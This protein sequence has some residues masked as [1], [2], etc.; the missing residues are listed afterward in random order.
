MKISELLGVEDH[1][2]DKYVPVLNNLDDLRKYTTSLRILYDCM[3]LTSPQNSDILLSL[4]ELTYQ[5]GINSGLNY[6][7]F[8][9]NF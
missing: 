7:K 6:N 8:V 5:S 9:H 3:L 1:P 2:T 4:L